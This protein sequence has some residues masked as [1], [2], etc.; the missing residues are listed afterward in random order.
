MPNDS[1]TVFAVV[2][3]AG[4]SSRFGETKQIAEFGGV[5]L[6]QRAVK[7]ASQVFGD[8]V[9]TVIGH[10]AAIVLRSM[11]ACSGFLVVNEAYESGLGSSISAAA[12][13]CPT[14]TDALLLLLAD[15]VLVTADHLKA[16]LRH[17]S[18]TDDEIVA[19]A[20]ADSEG[21]P[22]LMPRATFDELR[23]LSGDTGARALLRDPRFKLTTVRFEDAAFDIDTRADLARN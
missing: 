16:L 15:Q 22:V 17:W 3:A 14:Q 12:R 9:I 8:S 1:K 4:T 6:V 21:P 10:D 20:Y 7:T 13:A 11:R 2:L 18:G 19:T 23:D 5:P